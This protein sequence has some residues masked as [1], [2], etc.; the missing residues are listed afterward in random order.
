M[1]LNLNWDRPITRSAKNRLNRKI[2]ERDNT[3]MITILSEYPSILFEHMPM[4]P[5][6]FN[7]IVSKGLINVL[8]VIISW[9]STETLADRLVEDTNNNPFHYASDTDLR[10]INVL[11]RK[12]R[13][14]PMD[15][16][17]T[18]L[19]YLLAMQTNDTY[20]FP[21]YKVFAELRE[22]YIEYSRTP[23]QA[24]KD[25]ISVEYTNLVEYFDLDDGKKFLEYS[26]DAAVRVAEERDDE[27]RIEEFIKKWIRKTE[28]NIYTKNYNVLRIMGGMAG[29]AYLN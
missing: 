26:L 18:N 17:S 14:A 29:L 19:N 5:K 12:F 27:E 10:T 28:I 16:D 6:F 11:L 8:S 25:E 22:K 4:Q 15:F 20:L 9:I 3:G 21:L 13:N 1:S 2:S 7:V 24:L 23:T